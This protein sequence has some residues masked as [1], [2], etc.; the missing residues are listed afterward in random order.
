MKNRLPIIVAVVLAIVAVMAM[1]AYVGR[2]KQENQKQ[3]EGKKFVAAKV[4]ISANTEIES[5]MIT[6]REIPD[7]FVPAQAIRGTKK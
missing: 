6:A 7:Q 1:R 4:D 2:V 5:S 3:L